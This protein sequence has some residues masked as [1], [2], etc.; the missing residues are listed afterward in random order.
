MIFH[1]QIARYM[2]GA[3][4]LLIIYRTRDEHAG[5]LSV[6]RQLKRVRRVSL[7]HIGPTWPDV[8]VRRTGDALALPVLLFP[9]KL[10]CKGVINMSD[11][12]SH[13]LTY[14][15]G[16]TTFIVTPVYVMDKGESLI[17][18]LLKLMEADADKI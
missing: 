14:H 6:L 5:N 9:G 3:F 8:W 16:N 13:T 11:C 18:I 17:S 1:P 2:R 10:D 12:S 7:P 4:P 15:V